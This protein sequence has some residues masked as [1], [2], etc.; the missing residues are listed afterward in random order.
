MRMLLGDTPLRT[1]AA[2]GS[3]LLGDRLRTLR[4]PAP[5]A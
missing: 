5:P 1:S 3:R 2:Y 4:R